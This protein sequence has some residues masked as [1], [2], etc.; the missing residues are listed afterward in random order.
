MASNAKYTKYNSALDDIISIIRRSYLGK[1]VDEE[2]LSD[3]KSLMENKMVATG[4]MRTDKIPIHSD[5]NTELERLPLP[6]EILVKIFGYLDIQEISQCAQVSHQFD[7]I[8]K[9]ASLWKSWGKISVEERKVTTEFLTYIIERGIT[10]LSLIECEILPPKVKLTRPLKLKTLS[11][12]H[13]NGDASLLNEIL[14]S[15]SMEKLDSTH[16]MLSR[17]DI[18]KF[19]KSLPQN[20]SRLKSLN[21][22]NGLLGK[23][24][25]LSNI[26]LIVNS[27]LG[28]EELSLCGNSIQEEAIAYLC[29]NL[30]SNLLKLDIQD[31]GMNWHEPNDELND[32]NVRALVKSCPKLKVLD[33]R[34]NEKVTYQGLVAIIDGLHFLEYLGLPES[35]GNE[36]GLPKGT[37]NNE[38]LP[39]TINLPKMQ[40]LKSMKTL[41]EL[42]I[43]D[44]SCSNE[45]QSILKKEIPHLRKHSGGQNGS[46]WFGVGA[47]NKNELNKFRWIDFCPNCL[48]YDKYWHRHICLQK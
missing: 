40:A 19:I 41:K 42:L 25:D 4:V 29:E 13:T 16:C 27:C 44:S 15:H 35:V 8:S 34:S 26:S 9:D 45:Y 22:E 33:I 5:L 1:P 6:N 32:N 20:G 14:T 2:F 7:M 10:E 46:N 30:T 23:Y 36:L 37:W 38:I 43:G 28:L 3:L 24:C 21:L 12:D 11:L 48:R 47:M 31:I 17:D 39:Y 18:Y